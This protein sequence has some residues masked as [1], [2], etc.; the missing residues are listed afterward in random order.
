MSK[1][2]EVL[3][4]YEDE[5]SVLHHIH[6]YLVCKSCPVLMRFIRMR[7]D[8]MMLPRKRL[9]DTYL[10]CKS[11]PVIM[12]FIH[13]RT[14]NIRCLEKGSSLKLYKKL[15][16]L[17]HDKTNKIT[18]APSENSDQPRLKFRHS[19][20][21]QCIALLLGRKSLQFFASIFH[22]ALSFPKIIP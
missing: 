9:H 11:C 16:E 20:S 22:S 14:D 19:L 21:S 8:N 12:R 3:Q 10:V 15:N 5:P 2:F 6:T 4:N 1:F 13:M 7:T 18:C 17:Q